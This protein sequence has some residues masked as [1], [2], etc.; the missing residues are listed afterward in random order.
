MHFVNKRYGDTMFDVL[1]TRLGGIFES[2]KGRGSLNESAVRDAMREIRTALLEADVA[3]PVVKSFIDKVTERAVGVEVT[4]SVTPGQQVVKIVHD[5][6]VEMLQ[7]DEASSELNLRGE[8]PH[9]IMMVGLQGSG[10]TT[11]TAKVALSLT[12]KR[13]QKV[14]MVSLDVAR[15]AAQE[16]LAVL[17]TQ[18]GVATLPIVAG[19]SP[20]DIAR[21][22]IQAGKLGGYDV[23][24]LD[25]A[26]R[27]SIDAQL[28]AE[29]SDIKSA[30]N[31]QEI[32][33]V[34]DA[35]SGQDSVQT[36]KNFNDRLG[37]TGIVLTRVDGDAR[38]G[39]ALSMRS[40]TGCGIKFMGVGEKVEDLEPFDAGR[41]AGRI[42]GMG[43]V[44]ALV[45][46]AQQ[47]T[48]EEEA[49]RLAK[50]MA[51]GQFDLNDLKT[52]LAQMRKMGGL[53]GIMGMLPGVGKMK[54]QMEKSGMNENVLL[55][56][57]AI[58]SSMTK[59]ERKTPKILHASRKKR[60]AN[61]SGTT[62]Q[63]VN[64]ILK[65]FQTM[66]KVMKQMG[67]MGGQLPMGNGG[68]LGGGNPMAGMDLPGLPGGKLPKGFGF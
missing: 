30:T 61:G 58:I 40:I 66:A 39:A 14:L 20:V 56:Q 64:K 22:A 11:S 67:K 1:Q 18:V 55:R 23:V 9:V 63:E 44:V 17:G 16:Q 57:E 32:L 45:E 10:K 33:L 41:V 38:G 36:A 15:P 8:P 2:L 65:Q 53:S 5:N 24:M 60:I 54:S 4:K 48:N 52:Q 68:A 62:V 28:M 50:R 47:A 7:G 21:R 31:P 43:D 51:S 42:L 37:L 3:L 6:L 34:A 49:E 29:V 35:M 46:K 19:Q 13:K 27:L 25:T 26:G 12:S 59:S